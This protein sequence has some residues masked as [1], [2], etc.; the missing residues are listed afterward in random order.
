M[1]SQFGQLGFLQYSNDIGLNIEAA[2]IPA[3]WI[4]LS[5]GYLGVL[6]SPISDDT[7]LIMPGYDAF[8]LGLITDFRSP[9]GLI[10]RATPFAAW[11]ETQQIGLYF[12]F[13]GVD[14]SVSWLFK[15]DCLG[16]E[17]GIGTSFQFRKD[18]GTVWGLNL[19]VRLS[20]QG[21]ELAQDIKTWEQQNQ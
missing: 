3:W 19:Q 18:I 8:R 9:D 2:I 20:L 12:F 13:L 5:C 11:A 4:G 17:P 10:V 21:A 15:L 7:P 16:I 1:I 14:C 6:P